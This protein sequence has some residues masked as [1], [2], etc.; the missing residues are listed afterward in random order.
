[1]IADN[2]I[3]HPDSN[4]LLVKKGI[5]AH[6]V[7]CSGA[8]NS[9]L[10]KQIRSLYPR[11]YKTYRRIFESSNSL[12]SKEKAEIKDM[13]LGEVQHVEINKDLIISNCFTQKYYGRKKEVQYASVEALRSCLEE[14]LDKAKY[15][16]KE[17]HLPRICSGLGGLPWIIVEK[18]IY[19]V[20]MNK[21][22][23]VH[24]HHK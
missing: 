16:N 5:I 7:N 11:V 15:E 12:N 17:I 14:L 13:I 19:D 4:I 23:V 18:V 8:F 24:I 1:M 9:G 20:F 2:I 22:V 10:A 3:H 21:D 6:G